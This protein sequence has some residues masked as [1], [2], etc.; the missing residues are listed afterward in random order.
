MVSTTIN[1]S[2]DQ[3]QLQQFRDNFYELSQQ[4]KSKL[5]G[6]GVAIFMSS[7]GKTH[8]FG[9]IGGLEL[10]KVEG[11]NP[12]K[13][14]EDYSTDNRLFT[15]ARFTKTVLID[16]KDDIDELIASP[17][18]SIL[19]MLLKA[20]ERVI[21]RVIMQ[22]ALGA[23]K[24]GAP[25]TT[26]TEITAANDGVR[27]VD[28]TAG[29]TYEKIQEITQNFINNEL[30]YEDFS[31][32]II[33]ISGSENT[34]LMGEEEFIN[35][36]YITSRPVE[37]GIM[38]KTGIYGIVPFAGS[39]SSVT[40]KNP[41]LPEGSTTRSCAILAPKSIA[42]A[43]ELAD[44]SVEKAS[45]KVNSLEVTIDFWIGAMRTEGVKVQKVTTTI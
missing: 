19:S 17:K 34:D 16:K 32:S 44:L 13:Q 29:F 11:R 25:D 28:A 35:N 2:I 43:M 3:V 41:V 23:V 7:K 38:R 10:D 14:Y 27:T 21:D 37:E 39:D 22:A 1:P 12:D 15:K 31:G 6:S 45:G 5:V 42:V 24:V 4:T 9:R 36:D 40:K 20:K 18:S 26:P 8:N 33:A 30:D